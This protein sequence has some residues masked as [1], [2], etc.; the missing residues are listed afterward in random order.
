MDGPGRCFKIE[1]VLPYNKKQFKKEFVGSKANITTRNF[2]ETVQKIRKKLNIKDGGDSYLF[3]TTDRID[4]KMV[5][6]TH[7]T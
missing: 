3:F 4:E 5:I 1:S 6:V 2:P 7:K